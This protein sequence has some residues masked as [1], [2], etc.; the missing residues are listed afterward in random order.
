MRTLAVPLAVLVC[1]SVSVVAG[2]APVPMTG[3][4]T[5]SSVVAADPFQTELSATQP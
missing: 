3:T 4:Q 1:E 2:F 5:Q